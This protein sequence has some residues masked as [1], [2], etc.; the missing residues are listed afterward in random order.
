[1]SIIVSPKYTGLSDSSLAS[2]DTAILSTDYTIKKY[3]SSSW[4]VVAITRYKFGAS[5]KA[6]PGEVNYL[7]VPKSLIN[8]NSQAETNNLL[9]TPNDDGD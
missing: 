4:K 7:I 5:I 2:N 9:Q 8:R 1:W 6:E 3:D